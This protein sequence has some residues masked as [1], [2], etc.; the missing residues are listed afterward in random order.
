MSDPSN[1]RSGAAVPA[2]SGN[3]ALP[4]GTRLAEFEIREVL[5]AGGFGIVYRAWDHALQRDVALKEYMPVSL[6]GR[7]A[8]QRVTLRTSAHDDSFAVGL[9]S[10]VNE[11]RLLARFDHPALVKVFRFW[12]GNGT[13]Y[14]AMPL[15]KGRNL[16]ELRKERGAG[17]FDDA[18]MRA[19]IEPLLGALETMHDA[20]VYHRDIAPD[21]ILWC[22]NQ[23]PV[24]LD[25]GAAR[26]VLADRTQN[27]TAIL[28]P[29]FAPIEQYAETQSM[30]QGPWTDLY[31]LAGTCYF[32]LT[33]RAPLPATGRVM[34]DELEPLAR[35]APRGCSKELLRVLDWAMAV[36]PQDRPQSVTQMR[37]ALAGRSAVPG[38][39]TAQASAATASPAP[40]VDAGYEKTIQATMRVAPTQRI[41]AP[42]APAR[43][44]R[45][46][47]ELEAPERSVMLPPKSQSPLKALV[48]LLVLGAAAAGAWTTRQQ[49]M[50]MVGLKT[51]ALAAAEAASAPDIAASDAAGSPVAASA[52]VAE[53]ASASAP[54]SQALATTEEAVASTPAVVEAASAAPEPARA[55]E[56]AEAAA[57]AKSAREARGKAL[58]ARIAALKLPPP[59]LPPPPPGA[60][61]A[62]DT[63]AVAK[64]APETVAPVPSAA[65]PAARAPN[66]R[67]VCADQEPAKIAACVKKLCDNDARFEHYPICKRMRRQELQQQRTGSE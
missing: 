5:G 54:P 57:R 17:G 14:M 55:A 33:G 31:A 16:R 9:Q 62:T 11:A 20:A 4:T 22:D 12:E 24:L 63:S 25:F 39:A 26:L 37:D 38:P 2:E 64:P 7:G 34:G 49:W 15:Y 21:N 67:E 60:A 52:P 47:D 10:F 46:P 32:L 3:D 18:W 65:A 59:V 53:A 35:I 29:Q 28:K 36:R 6:A 61:G 40:P 50:P 45:H 58:E 41:P 13:A 44:S 43:P 1:T 66:W 56:K 23:R 27:V 19:L 8:G 48:L 51:A 42:P 30:R